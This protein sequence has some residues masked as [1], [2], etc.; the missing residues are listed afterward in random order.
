MLPIEQHTAGRFDHTLVKTNLSVE[1]AAEGGSSES[2][3]TETLFA[4]VVRSALRSAVRSSQC[5]AWLLKDHHGFLGNSKY[6][7]ITGPIGKVIKS[8]AI[9]NRNIRPLI[10]AKNCHKSD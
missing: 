2:I 4:Q 3:A 9:I 6:S 5:W 10:H 8:L 7:I 1:F